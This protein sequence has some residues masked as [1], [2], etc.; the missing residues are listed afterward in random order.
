MRHLSRA[1]RAGSLPALY[2]L[3][4]RYALPHS[5]LP[6]PIAPLLHLLVP[7]LACA[8]GVQ[9]LKT[10]SETGAWAEVHIKVRDE[11]DEALQ[12]LQSTNAGT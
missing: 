2:S 6:E 3:L 1:D 10:H 7:P 11:L 12:N 9:H 5:S 8:A 4:E